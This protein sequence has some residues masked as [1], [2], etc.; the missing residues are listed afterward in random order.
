MRFNKYT[1]LFILIFLLCGLFKNICIILFIVITHELAHV[2]VAKALGYKIISINIYPFGGIT[3]I[4][5]KLNDH[6]I[7]DLLI[8]SAGIMLQL[9]YVFLY[10]LGFI[11]SEL[12]HTYNK[13]I[14]LFNLLPIIPLDGSKIVFELANFFMPYKKSLSCY[15]IISFISIVIYALSNLKYNLNNYFIITLF[16]YK[17]YQMYKNQKIIYYKFILERKLYNFRYRKIKNKNEQISKY[18]KDIKYYYHLNG[19]IVDEKNII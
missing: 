5:K 10:K 17:T 11:H 7:Y 3:K 15:V 4:D 18:Q 16:I 2:L 13:A 6:I 9:F 19:K 8:A 12:F 14:L 1:L